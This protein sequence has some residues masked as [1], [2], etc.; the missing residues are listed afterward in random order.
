MYDVHGATQYTSARCCHAEQQLLAIAGDRG[1]RVVCDV[2]VGIAIAEAAAN[3]TDL[4]AAQA[5]MV[6]D[7][8]TSGAVSNSPSPRPAP[9]RPPPCGSSAA[10][11][12]T[13]AARSSGSHRPR[14][15][16]TSS[17]DAIEGHTDTLAKLTWTLAH[18]PPDQWPAWV[19]RIGPRTLVLI[20]E[21]GQASTTDLATA[22]E[23]IT[24]RGGIVRLIGD[25]Q[26][27]AA[28]GAGGVLRD[29]AAH[30]RRRHPHRGPPL[31]R[32]RRGRCH[33]R[34]PRRRSHALGFYADHDRIH[35]GDLGAAT[36]QAYDAWTADRAA[37]LD[38][39]LLAPTRDLVT[40][41]NA[42]A[43]TDRLAQPAVSRTRSRGA[44]RRWDR[45]SA[46]T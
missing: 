11:G 18:A 23:F 17:A 39:V 22:V 20:D 28:V 32:P 37:G 1:G 31:P 9:G 33:P 29:I 12:P 30:R 19:S 2:R 10:P 35:V 38:S 46:V 21:A 27:L 34:A 14:R 4:N 13:A 5:A 6:R 36:D 44:A 42:R 3:G 45:A 24:G 43:R 41:L 26:Q 25:D 15:P 40:R 16:P 7:L 8:A